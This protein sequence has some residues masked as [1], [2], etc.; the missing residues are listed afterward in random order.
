MV[1]D[2]PSSLLIAGRYR[3][4]REIGRGGMGIVWLGHDVVLDRQVALKRLAADASD[5]EARIAAQLHHPNVVAVYDL[6]DDPREGRWLVME[7]VD[8]PSL[9]GLVRDAGPLAP[10]RARQVLIQVAAALRA[11]QAAGITHRDVKPSNVLVGAD[12]V[13]KLS[14][15]GIARAS[16]DATVTQTGMIVGSPA[17]VAPEVATGR[18][19]DHAADV[20]SLGATAYF[21]LTG[22]SPFEQAEGSTALSTLYRIVHEEPP[23]PDAGG[24]LAPLLRHAM[25]KVPEQRW[26][27]DQVASFLRDGT[28]P[29]RGTHEM[30]SIPA[31]RPMAPRRSGRRV[32]VLAAVVAVVAVLAVLGYLA[33]HRP[34]HNTASPASPSHVSGPTAAGMKSFIR[35]YVTT[36][37]DNPAAAWTMLTPKFQRESGGYAK[38]EAFWGPATNGRVVSIEANPADLTVSYHRH[39]DSFRNGPSPTVLQLVYEDGRYLIDGETSKGFV[40]A[41]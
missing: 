37:A 38:Y 19:A 15:F 12:G 26:S 20:W 32:L 35:S 34:S 28:V 11:A 24:P 13:V 40:P 4:E 6:A 2:T 22:A 1:L 18:H 16:G 31:A 41:H 30:A 10:E 17:Y 25:V 23:S 29:S 36:V 27:I 9:A 33:L 8:G 5:R 21:L 3:L 14:D 39:F 7:H